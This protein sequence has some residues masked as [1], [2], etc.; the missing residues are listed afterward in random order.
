M[1]NDLDLHSNQ[2]L[3]PERPQE[4]TEDHYFASCL[5]RNDLI[6]SLLDISKYYKKT[7]PNNPRVRL[8]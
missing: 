1:L 6:T 2:P 8:I 7:F 3:L 5:N 4:Q